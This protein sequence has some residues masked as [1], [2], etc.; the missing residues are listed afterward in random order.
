VCV[1]VW[2]W[3]GC[4]GGVCVHAY[5]HASRSPRAVVCHRST[6]GSR[7]VSASFDRHAKV[8]DAE[9]GACLG[10]YSNK[11]VPYCAKF[12]PKDE[13]II[14]TGVSDK[15]LVQYDVRSG[16]QVLEYDHHLG[17]VNTITFCDDA[18]RFVSTS[19][20]KKVLVWEWNIPVP[21]KYISEPTM[22]SIP[23]VTLHPSGEFFA[24]QSMDNTIVVYQCGDKF[25]QMRKKLFK[26]HQNAGYACQVGFS[27]D[28]RFLMSGDGDG[29]LWFW[30]WKTTK[31][32]RKIQAHDH[33]VC[34][35]A[36]WNPIQPSGV[37]TCGWDGSIRYFE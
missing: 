35:G 20:D 37:A 9:T 7:F 28:G 24:G 3:C 18:R 13:N 36:V 2:V 29:K 5:I 14:I 31:L 19:D 8:W 12:Y 10:T 30:D 25:R 32:Y 1:C 21:I 17:A 26:G 11:K 23:S 4:G 15:K 22:H 34:M 27:P 33:G 6:S 16:E